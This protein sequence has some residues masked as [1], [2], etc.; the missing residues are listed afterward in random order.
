MLVFRPYGLFSRKGGPKGIRTP[1]EPVCQDSDSISGGLT[2][3]QTPYNACY[4]VN[5]QYLVSESG[6]TSGLPWRGNARMQERRLKRSPRSS[7]TLRAIPQNDITPVSDRNQH[8]PKYVWLGR[9]GS[10]CKSKSRKCKIRI[11][12]VG[13]KWGRSDSNRRSRDPEPRIIPS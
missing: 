11:W 4:L 5:M 10:P 3:A 9:L 2:G 13:E 1:E 7:D 6:R 8:S 12:P